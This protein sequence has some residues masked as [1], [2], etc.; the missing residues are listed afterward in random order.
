M[1]VGTFIFIQL[2][3]VI[4]RNEVGMRPVLH[5]GRQ[6]A[7]PPGRATKPPET[8]TSGGDHGNISPPQGGDILHGSVVRPATPAFTDQDMEV[9]A[10]W[11]KAVQQYRL[12]IEIDND[13]EFLP[14]ALTITP[15]AADEPRWIVHRTPAGT[16]AVR[17]WPGVADVVPTVQ[18]ALDRIA[19]ALEDD[20]AAQQGQT[21]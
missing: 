4:V 19:D 16:V 5:I 14:G 11:E 2:R 9:I 12:R 13:H 21:S 6:H 7:E 10:A 15:A 18:E 17:P 3:A 1:L 20:G 8:A